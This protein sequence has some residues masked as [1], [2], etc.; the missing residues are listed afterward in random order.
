M[1]FKVSKELAERNV[2]T[3]NKKKYGR[4]TLLTQA[5]FK[6]TK[7]SEVKKKEFVPVP[8]VEAMVLKFSSLKNQ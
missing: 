7:K 6:N 5:F 2:G 8:K 4:M 3:G 1:S